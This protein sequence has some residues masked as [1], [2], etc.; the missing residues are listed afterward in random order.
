MKED[1]NPKHIL[2]Q[3]VPVESLSDE[4]WKL[5]YRN[6]SS[7]NTITRPFISIFVFS[8]CGEEKENEQFQLAIRD[9]E[10]EKRERGYYNCHASNPNGLW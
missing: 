6:Y 7:K 5:Y 9:R 8:I 2:S 4:S 10:E 3:K 1:G